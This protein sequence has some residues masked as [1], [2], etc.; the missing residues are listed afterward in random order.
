MP[1]LDLRAYLADRHTRTQ[2][3]GGAPEVE[4]I[5]K[6]NRRQKAAYAKEAAARKQPLQEFLTHVCDEAAGLTPVHADASADS[7][8]GAAP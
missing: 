4:I 7:G 2:P 5:L 3:P 1:T 6:V 8:H